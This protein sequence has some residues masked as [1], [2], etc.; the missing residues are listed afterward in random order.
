MQLGWFRQD[1]QAV[2][3]ALGR[4][5]RPYMATT[6]ASGPLDELLALHIELGVFEAL[7]EGREHRLA[8]GEIAGAGDRHDALARLGK[9]MKLAKGGDIVE[10]GIGTGVGNHN[11]PVPHQHSTTIRHRCFPALLVWR[12]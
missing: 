11:K 9:D 2:L 6:M 3:E 4:G 7:G 5:V 12:L 10:P 8:D 1:K